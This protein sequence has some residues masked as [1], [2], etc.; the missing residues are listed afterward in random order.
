MSNIVQNT[1]TTLVLHVI[2][3]IILVNVTKKIVHQYLNLKN[4]FNFQ[5]TVIKMY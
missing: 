5:Y 1:F 4:V 2:L 3:F